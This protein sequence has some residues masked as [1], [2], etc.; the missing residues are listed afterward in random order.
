MN[1]RLRRLSGLMVM[2]MVMGVGCA[3]MNMTLQN[4]DYKCYIG[5]DELEF[6]K[7]FTPLF[8][9]APITNRMGI[10]DEDRYVAE[11]YRCCSYW[12]GY[13]RWSTYGNL[14]KKYFKCVTCVN[15]KID[16]IYYP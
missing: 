2:V 10:V 11:G 13:Y 7:Q 12:I 8:S 6:V 5:M 1:S 14:D 9:N 3:P 15:G 4:T 16:S